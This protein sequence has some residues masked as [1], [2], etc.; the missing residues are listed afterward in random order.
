MRLLFI[1]LIAFAGIP[2]LFAQ[3]NLVSEVDK[4]MSFGTRPGF[5][6]SFPNTDKR[7]VEDTWTDFVKANFGAKMKKGKKGEKSAAECRSASVS[8]NNFTLYSAVE[9]I[10]DGAQLNVWFDLGPYF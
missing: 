4:P 3:Y 1:L 10:G 2:S 5:A 9:T 6:V 7:L 8:A